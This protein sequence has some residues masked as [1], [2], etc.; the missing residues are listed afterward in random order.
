MAGKQPHAGEHHI[1]PLPVYFKVFWGLIALTVLTVA[2]TRV[3][4]GLFN[5]IVAFGIAT[6]KAV[7]VLG[8]FMHLKYDNMMNR[9]ILLSGFFFLLVLW[10]FSAIDEVTRVVQR[11][12]L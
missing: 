8:F 10:F 7:L 11:S 5:A 6:F 9:V 4:F 12:T 3:D 1:I 2:V